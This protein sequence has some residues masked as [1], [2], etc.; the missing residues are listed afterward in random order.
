M[1][2]PAES[3]PHSFISKDEGEREVAGDQDRRRAFEAVCVQAIGH[4]RF[5]ERVG[6]GLVLGRAQCIDIM[7]D[8]VDRIRTLG[9][10]RYID[11]QLHPERIADTA[12]PPRLAGLTTVTLSQRQIAEQYEMPQLE[13]RRQK[14]LNA[15]GD[16]QPPAPEVADNLYEPRADGRIET[17]QDV[18]VRR[19][20]LTLEARLFPVRAVAA[21][22][23]WAAHRWG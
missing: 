12:M 7:P 15:N 4:L 3:A 21:A 17:V 20:S 22:Q 19:T 13:A 18:Y 9:I 14:K 10:Q 11:E 1:P 2:L 5:G 6:E 8:C 23:R 16:D